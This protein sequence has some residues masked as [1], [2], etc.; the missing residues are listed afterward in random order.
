VASVDSRA[1][2]QEMVRPQT[3]RLCEREG[4]RFDRQNGDHYIMVRDGSPYRHTRKK[5]LKEDVVLGVGRTLGLNRKQLER[6]LTGK[7]RKM[8]KGKAD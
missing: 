6:R 8:A 3:P 1:A 4:C 5:G 7:T 2:S